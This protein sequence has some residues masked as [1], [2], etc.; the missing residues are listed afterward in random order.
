MKKFEPTLSAH[1][2][3]YNDDEAIAVHICQS[4]FIDKYI[5]IEED[6]IQLETSLMTVAEIYAKYGVQV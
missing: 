1:L 5:V 3:L 6:P 2:H 4:G